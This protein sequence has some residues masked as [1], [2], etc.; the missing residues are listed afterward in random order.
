MN[1]EIQI[2]DYEGGLKNYAVFGYDLSDQHVLTIATPLQLFEENNH[3]E[4]TKAMFW[5][6]VM[7][8]ACVSGI[9]YMVSCPDVTAKA[10]IAA[11]PVNGQVVK[12]D[13]ISPKGM[14]LE[15]EVLKKYA[16]KLTVKCETTLVDLA[17]WNVVGKVE[18][19]A[20]D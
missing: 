9:E 3:M 13:I 1:F 11:I 12:G 8:D 7:R 2:I 10:D 4:K 17:D 20:E 16:G 19:T 14:N 5:A 18:A 6:G 15:F